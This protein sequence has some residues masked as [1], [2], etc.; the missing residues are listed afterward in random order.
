MSLNKQAEISLGENITQ[1]PQLGSKHQSYSHRQTNHVVGD[2]V[3]QGH[4]LL[5]P[6]AD[7]HPRGHALKTH[8][9]PTQKTARPLHSLPP[10]TYQQRVKELHEGVDREGFRDRRHNRSADS[11]EQSHHVEDFPERSD[12]REASDSRVRREDVSQER[13]AAG[14]DHALTHG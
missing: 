8:R 10:P 3:G 12:A 14:E 7:E 2:Q 5:H 1:Y 11:E 6:G 4:H 13:L 9:R